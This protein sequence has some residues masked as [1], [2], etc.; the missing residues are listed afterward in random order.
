MKTRVLKGI[1]FVLATVLGFLGFGCNKPN[2]YMMEGDFYPE[3]MYGVSFARSAT[4]DVSGKIKDEANNEPIKNIRVTVKS[5][6]GDFQG[7]YTKTNGSYSM[8]GAGVV[9]DSLNI[10]AED[11]TGVYEPDSVQVEVV[12]V[13]GKNKDDRYAGKATVHQDFQ[14]KKK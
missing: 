3:L 14:L 2:N 9:C 8:L 5:K 4:Y 10:V 7:I 11:T 12:L 1:N 6:R 13:P